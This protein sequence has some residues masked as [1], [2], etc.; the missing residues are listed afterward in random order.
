MEAQ[1]KD[2]H[3]ALAN[4]LNKTAEMS[5][6]YVH[7]TKTQMADIYTKALMGALSAG[8]LGRVGLGALRSVSGKNDLNYGP[9]V[10]AQTLNIAARESDDE[11]NFK[12]ANARNWLASIIKHLP[13]VKVT[14]GKWDTAPSPNIDHLYKGLTPLPAVKPAYPALTKAAEMS[15]E[16]FNEIN[17]PASGGSWDDDWGNWEGKPFDSLPYA[18]MPTWLKKRNAPL[19]EIGG[20]DNPT[21]EE[22]NA[23]NAKH[24]PDNDTRAKDWATSVLAAIKEQPAREY[25]ATGLF[26]T[27]KKVQK[28]KGGFLGFGGEMVDTD[29]DEYADLSNLKDA[30]IFNK[31]TTPTQANEYAK[32]MFA[33][34]ILGVGQSHDSN[35]LSESFPKLLDV[36]KKKKWSKLSPEQQDVVDEYLDDVGYSEDDFPDFSQSKSMHEKYLSPEQTNALASLIEQYKATWPKTAA[37]YPALT[38]KSTEL[39]MPFNT[40]RDAFFNPNTDTGLLSGD[41]YL[42]TPREG[43]VISRI[44]G[45]GDTAL[46][47]WGVPATYGAVPAALGALY[48]G[49]K[50]T[51]YILDK[52]RK[53]TI[54]Q[55]LAAAQKAYD[56]AIAGQDKQAAS[57]IVDDMFDRMAD[58]A[59]TES[60][61]TVKQA[62]AGQMLLGGYGL[63]GVLSSL[64][65]G[66]P[67]YKFFENRSKR[68][69]IA[70]ALRQRQE[71]K[72][73]QG[74]RPI[75]A[76]SDDADNKE[77]ANPLSLEV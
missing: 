49:Y 74:I 25:A 76:Y 1:A 21:L 40:V 72:F 56:Q 14:T 13:D 77:D 75:Y 15:P 18:H 38:K 70:K 39:P 68:E 37:A 30:L 12:T 52:R 36:I 44:F 32:R 63:Y 16:L 4:N 3:F 24:T 42:T 6:R 47:A 69:M 33:G 61:D 11:E 43:N 8:I 73:G 35:Y 59:T 50:L 29:K 58:I 26:P 19:T 71:K 53:A 41:N 7:S 64:A 5:P 55:E 10:G 65:A 22:Y 54:D 67:S 66:I 9:D 45:M 62:N 20:G 57:V 17:W 34:D 23:W 51:D 27:G 2:L 60:A 31:D 28:R 46:G 48:G